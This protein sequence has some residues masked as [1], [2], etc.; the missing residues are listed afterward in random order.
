MTSFRRFPIGIAFALGVVITGSAHG[1]SE[2]DDENFRE[3]VLL[4]E[5]A[6]AKL[7][8]CCPD[9]DWSTVRCDYRHTTTGGCSDGTADLEDPALNLG[10]SHCVLDTSCEEIQRSG[11]CTRAKAAQPYLTKVRRS[12]NGPDTDLGSRSHPPVCP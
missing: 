5:E 9:V 8:T 10:E 7:D 1:A 11:V 3:E 6:V 12:P 2:T 4:C